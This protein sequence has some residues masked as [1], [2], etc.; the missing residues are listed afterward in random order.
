M[1]ADREASRSNVEMTTEMPQ[2][3]AAPAPAPYPRDLA[4]YETNC[5]CSSCCCCIRLETAAKII[6]YYGIVLWCVFGVNM[7]VTLSLYGGS[8]WAPSAVYKYVTIIP[9]IGCSIEALAN[10]TIIRNSYSKAFIGV[11][12]IWLKSASIFLVQVGNFAALV[13][14]KKVLDIAGGTVGGSA[15]GFL[16]WAML[17]IYFILIMKSYVSEVRTEEPYRPDPSLPEYPMDYAVP[18]V[19]QHTNN[20]MYPSTYPAPMGTPISFQPGMAQKQPALQMPGYAPNE[21]YP[22]PKRPYNE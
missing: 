15:I 12:Y 21:A 22:P 9:F 4:S 5:S 2:R 11:Y 13:A 6:S 3:G 17:D 14:Q 16:L 20:V 1:E 10:I 18:V 7:V 8:E 19:V